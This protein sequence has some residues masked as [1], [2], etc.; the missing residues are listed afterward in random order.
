MDKKIEEV[1]G[2][3]LTKLREQLGLDSYQAVHSRINEGLAEPVIS[4]KTIQRAEKATHS[5]KI[6][7][8][9]ILA[10]FYG[11]ETWRLLLPNLGEQQA[12]AED[13]GFPSDD[14]NALPVGLKAYVSRKI[15]FLKKTMDAMLYITRTQFDQAPDD[16]TFWQWDGQLGDLI[17]KELDLDRRSNV[18]IRSANEER[19]GK[20][21]GARKDS[22]QQ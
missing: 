7:T 4:D 19:R 17:R 8:L 16:S 21:R 22:D 5:V 2:E 9:E 6:G 1:V 11:V 10:K 12:S 18:T 13:P 3:N 15:T 20:S 14:F